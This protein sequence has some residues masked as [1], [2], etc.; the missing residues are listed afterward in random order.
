MTRK[1]KE[2]KRKVKETIITQNQKYVSAKGY[3]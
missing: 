1:S 2:V 3:S